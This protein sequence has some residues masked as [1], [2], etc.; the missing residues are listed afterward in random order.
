MLQPWGAR[1]LA[2]GIGGPGPGAVAPLGTGMAP[3]EG[4]LKG[5]LLKHQFGHFIASVDLSHKQ[6]V[7]LTDRPA[8][9]SLTARSK[10]CSGHSADLLPEVA[11]IGNPAPPISGA[12]REARDTRPGG[13]F[14]QFGSFLS[15]NLM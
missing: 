7:P 3:V 1:V 15:G 11:T 13:L 5:G 4:L 9:S 10:L 8:S 6:Q 14:G 12:V 2:K